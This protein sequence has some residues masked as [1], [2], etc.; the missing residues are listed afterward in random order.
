MPAR[1]FLLLP[2]VRGK[3]REEEERNGTGRSGTGEGGW[4]F[5]PPLNWMENKTVE[6]NR[7]EEGCFLSPF[8]LS[9]ILGPRQSSQPTTFT[10]DPCV[11]HVRHDGG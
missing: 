1:R 6:K 3:R 2:F 9:T 5:L 4:W 8:H 7:A 11:R 10:E